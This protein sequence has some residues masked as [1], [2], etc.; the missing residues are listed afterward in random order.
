VNARELANR[1]LEE[2]DYQPTARDIAWTQWQYAALKHGGLWF[3]PSSQSTW[4]IDK[5]KKA[6][7][8]Q[9]GDPNHP[10]NQVI[11]TVAE[12]AG[13]GAIMGD[14]NQQDFAE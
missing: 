9:Q 12:A 5:V 7:V 10:L 8:L 11:K 6:F 1:L 13:F 2:D 4:V 3:V 14:E